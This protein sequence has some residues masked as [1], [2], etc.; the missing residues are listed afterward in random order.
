MVSIASYATAFILI[1]K[2]PTKMDNSLKLVLWYIP[3]LLEVF[4]HFLAN[5]V[6]GKVRYDPN[7]VYARAATAF[8]IILGGGTN[9]ISAM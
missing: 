2:G 1:G 3:I 5:V 7:A 6:P 8:I 4:S 9:V